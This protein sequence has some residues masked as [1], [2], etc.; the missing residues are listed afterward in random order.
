M[1][2]YTIDCTKKLIRIAIQ[3]EALDTISHNIRLVL[4]SIPNQRQIVL[5][6]DGHGFYRNAL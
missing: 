6:P 2:L 5:E 4:Q 1:G 3:V